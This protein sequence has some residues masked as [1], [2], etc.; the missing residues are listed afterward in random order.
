MTVWWGRRAAERVGCPC[1]WMVDFV[2]DGVEFRVRR[3]VMQDVQVALLMWRRGVVRSID[4]TSFVFW[5]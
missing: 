3:V 5:W 4:R 2:A 1:R